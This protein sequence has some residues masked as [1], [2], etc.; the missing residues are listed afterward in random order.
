MARRRWFIGKSQDWLEEQ[1][2][3]AQ[4]ELAAGAASTGGTEGDASFTEQVISN[5]QDRIDALLYELH[6]IAP[7]TYPNN[8]A[9]LTR[10][11][12]GVLRASYP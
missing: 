12:R 7:D 10:T 5:P 1:L 6:C 4:D 11:T 2:S 8:V 3:K 9:R